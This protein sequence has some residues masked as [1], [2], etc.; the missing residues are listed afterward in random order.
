MGKVR[1]TVPFI[2]IKD[3]YDYLTKIGIDHAAADDYLTKI[4]IGDNPI[5]DRVTIL[6]EK[7][8]RLKKKK[9]IKKITVRF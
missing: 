2:D 5:N 3:G 1:R 7:V 6:E 4:T 8:N 9:K